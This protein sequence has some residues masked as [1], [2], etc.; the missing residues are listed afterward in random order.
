M[1]R[2]AYLTYSVLR[3]GGSRRF[4]Q[5]SSGWLAHPDVF[6]Q[7]RR[8]VEPRCERGSGVRSRPFYEPF[9]NAN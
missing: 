4:R 8:P 1:K 3:R 2:R 9:R 6:D 5:S 7:N